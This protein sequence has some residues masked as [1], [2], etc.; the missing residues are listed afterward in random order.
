M[1][2][3][4]N[5][6]KNY[7]LLNQKKHRD[8]DGLFLIEGKKMVL[9]AISNNPE[10]IEEVIC[11]DTFFEATNFPFNGS[12]ST[13]SFNNLPK[14]SSLKTPQEIIAVV[15]KPRVMAK[16]IEIDDLVLVLEDISDPGN[17]GTIIRMADWFGIRHIACSHGSVDCFNPKVVQATMGGI[18]RVNISYTDINQFIE[19]AKE[20][21]I[22]VYG[23]LLNGEN[24]YKEQLSNKA[25]LVMGNESKG[26]S[27]DIERLI[28]NK[29]FIPNYLESGYKS[30]SLNL[31]TAT[32]IVLGEFRRQAFY[33][34]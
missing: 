20:N 27:P 9:E 24:I 30:E 17:L 22:P 33:S 18:F 32:A 14:I 3:S 15:Q 13:T 26:L 6:I 7:R 8:K 34:K 4:K 11:T 16:Y 31:S 21:R 2:L 5:K 1:E 29:L 12:I 25:I 10:L 28:D 23:T 19:L